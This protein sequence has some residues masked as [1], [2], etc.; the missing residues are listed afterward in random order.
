MN[1]L[2]GCQGFESSEQGGHQRPERFDPVPWRDENDDGNREAA[3]FC[4]CSRF[5]S[6]VRKASK[7]PAAGCSSSPFRLPVQ[8]IA[9][10]VRTSC[11]GSSRA[12]GRG[13][14]SS[15]RMR[16]GSQEVS[17]EFESRDCLFTLHGRKV[18]EK[19]IQSVPG[20]QVV[21]EVLHGHPGAAEDGRAPENLR[22]AV[23]DRLQR[24][25]VPHTTPEPVWRRG[26]A[27]QSPYFYEET[28]A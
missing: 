2:P 4:R 11:S 12:S 22:I 14:D 5:W 1:Q 25:H 17:G 18:V 3:A 10:T 13:R 15:R 6:A 8:P 26:E 19:L 16:T 28:S 7:S 9:A 21:E 27:Y 23:N 20:G 24:R